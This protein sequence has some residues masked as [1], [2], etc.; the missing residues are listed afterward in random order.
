MNVKVRFAAAYASS[1]AWNAVL[2]ARG[3]IFT[4]IVPSGILEILA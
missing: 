4:E 2:F 3:T 1:V